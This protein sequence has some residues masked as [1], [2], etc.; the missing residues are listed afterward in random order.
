[1]LQYSL[2]AQA[3]RNNDNSLPAPDSLGLSSHEP[4]NKGT[5]C[6]SFTGSQLILGSAVTL[7]L[8]FSGDSPIVIGDKYEYLGKEYE[9]KHG[10][11]DTQRYIEIVNFPA[12]AVLHYLPVNYTD[13]DG[14]A[15]YLSYCPAED[16]YILVNANYETQCTRNLAA[17]LYLY[18]K[19]VDDA[20]FPNEN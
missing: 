3:Y 11:R 6:N 10:M 19:A 16:L 12:F 20:Y 15:G 14:Y 13:K 17:A 1:M 7:R 9:V 2:Y 8:Y 5:N 4:V 18:A